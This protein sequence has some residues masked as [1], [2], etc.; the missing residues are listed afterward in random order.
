MIEIERGVLN[1]NSLRPIDGASLHIGFAT[2][3]FFQFENEMNVIRF[4][5]NKENWDINQII[6]KVQ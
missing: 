2:C 1:A 5:L 6:P 3:Q 4:I